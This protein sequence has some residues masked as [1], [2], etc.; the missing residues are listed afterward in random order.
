MFGVHAEI[1]NDANSPT[2]QQ[3]LQLAELNK[4]RNA[5]AVNPMRGLYSQRKGK[6]RAAKEKNDMEGF[7]TWCETE[8]K[9]KEAE[10][11]KKADEIEVEI[12]KLAKLQ[13]LKVEVKPAPVVAP[14]PKAKGKAAPK[15]PAKKAA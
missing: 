14:A 9:P 7:K 8:L 4:K 1:E 6:L 3:S 10:L 15:A 5:E 13:P 12:R 11:I 2:H